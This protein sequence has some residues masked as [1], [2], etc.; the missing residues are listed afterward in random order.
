MIPTCRFI[1]LKKAYDV[2]M[3]DEMHALGMFGRCGY[4][5]FEYFGAID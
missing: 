2:V 3:V 5:V 4:G 1:E